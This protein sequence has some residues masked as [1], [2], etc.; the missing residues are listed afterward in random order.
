VVVSFPSAARQ[1]AVSQAPACV[2]DILIET[3]GDSRYPIGMESKVAALE[4]IARVTTASLERIE[5]RLDTGLTYADDRMDRLERR[6]DTGLTY[7]DGRMDRVD[8]QL[9]VLL[10]E[11]H[12]DFRWLFGMMF[13]GAGMI[14]VCLVGLLAVIAHGFHWL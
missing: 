5:R 13:A 8:R 1:P 3:A 12:S 6:L 7:A 4:Q 14:L 9:D 2:P 10:T 11:Q